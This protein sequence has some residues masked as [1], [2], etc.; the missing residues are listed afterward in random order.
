MGVSD[1]G[2][3]GDKLDGGEKIESVAMKWLSADRGGST[4]LVIG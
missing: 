3:G 1:H 4:Y 2:E